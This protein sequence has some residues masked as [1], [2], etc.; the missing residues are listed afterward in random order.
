MRIDCI[1]WKY[2]GRPEHFQHRKRGAKYL[3]PKIILPGLTAPDSTSNLLSPGAQVPTMGGNSGPGQG[4]ALGSPHRPAGDRWGGL[5]D[6]RIFCGNRTQ[7]RLRGLRGGGLRYCAS[8]RL[9]SLRNADPAPQQNHPLCTHADPEEGKSRNFLLETQLEKSC[10]HI[11][12]GFYVL[13]V[14]GIDQL[15]TSNWLEKE[16]HLAL[17]PRSLAKERRGACGVVGQL[18]SSLSPTREHG[19]LEQRSWVKAEAGLAG[20][21]P[22]RARRLHTDCNESQIAPR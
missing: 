20:P 1:N 10:L 16:T 15:E 8:H 22:C 2:F 7:H 11:T 18:P 14:S 17:S 12:S 6:C 5:A 4:W 3:L 19:S 9:H 13:W 21:P